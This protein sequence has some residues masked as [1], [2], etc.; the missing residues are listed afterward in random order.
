M[1]SIRPLFRSN[2][3][4]G[5]PQCHGEF[6]E[7]IGDPLRG[8]HK[9]PLDVR[10]GTLKTELRK[11]PDGFGYQLIARPVQ[12]LASVPGIIVRARERGKLREYEANFL[13]SFLV[14]TISKQT[15]RQWLRS[16]GLA[17]FFWENDW[18]DRDNQGKFAL[19][20]FAC[21]VD[22]FRPGEIDWRTPNVSDMQLMA[23]LL[24]V[25]ADSTDNERQ[26]NVLRGLF[27]LEQDLKTVAVEISMSLSRS[28]REILLECHR[29]RLRGET[30][31]R[32]LQKMG[33]KGFGKSALTKFR[34]SP[35]SM[36]AQ[37][38]TWTREVLN[39]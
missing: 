10:R 37:I 20:A 38:S 16:S 23:K 25:F 14:K 8:R 9:T 29:L 24:K 31:A 27:D 39:D 6:Q 26:S 13:G 36:R 35:D 33:F 4:L 7:W 18:S 32:W 11:R 19:Y 2:G 22:F 12:K 34:E 17:N 5:T 28:D 30:R 21:F 3:R 15:F 1:R